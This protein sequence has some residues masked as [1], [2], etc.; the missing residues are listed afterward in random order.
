[1]YYVYLLRSLEHD[2]VYTGFSTDLKR[3][4]NEHNQGKSTHTNKFKPW[5]VVTYMSFANRKKAE[6]FEKYLK[7]GSGIAFARKH[8]L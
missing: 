8:F 4:L 1:M 2:E 5:T 6:E 7:T 3:R